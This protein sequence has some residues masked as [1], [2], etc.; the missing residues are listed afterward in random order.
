MS[1]DSRRRLGAITALVLGLFLGAHAVAAPVDR[2]GR[3]IPGP[4]LWHLLGAG[5]LGIPLLGIGLA[6]AGFDRLGG[7]DMKRAAVLIVGLSL[8]IPYIVGVLTNVQHGSLDYDVTQRGLAAR[9]VGVVPGFFAEVIAGRIGV[10]GAVLLGFLALSALTLATFA[11]HPLQR[12]ER[13]AAAGQSGSGGRRTGA[14]GAASGRAEA[15]APSGSRGGARGGRAHRAASP[16]RP[17]KE[18]PK[19]TQK[20]APVAAR[21]GVRASTD[22]PADGSAGTIGSECWSGGARPA[23]SIAD[24]DAAHLQGGRAARRANHRAGRDPVRGDPGAGSEGGTDRGSVGRPRD[25][26][27]GAVGTCRAD[28][29]EGRRR[30]G[31]SQPG[32]ADRD[33][34][35]AHRAGGL[36]GAAGSASDRARSRPG[37]EAGGRRPGQDAAPADRGRHRDGKVGHHQHDHHRSDLP[38]HAEG[39]AAPDDRPEDGRALHVQRAAASSTQGGDQQ[40]RRGHGAQVG[41]VRDAA[42]LRAAP[43]ERGPQPG[44]LQPQGRGRKAAPESGP[45]QADLGQHQRRS[46]GYPARIRRR[47]RPTPREC[48]R[49]SSSSSTSWP[50]S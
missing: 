25:R 24:R 44:R 20:P 13:G 14:R 35:R 30:G 1:A 23:G 45:T 50:T 39:T 36:G 40:P 27:A 19:K 15:E 4:F 17:R 12:L 6:L 46:P 38:L 22:Q 49:S 41:G 29:G 11:W 28:S 18:P 43:G 32:R 8:L 5:A 34:R 7:L 9:M 37:G 33:A 10:A 31:D 2:S 3:R 21:R 26:H 42:A 47:R 16:V 48:F